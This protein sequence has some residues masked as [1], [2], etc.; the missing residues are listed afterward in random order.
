[1]GT[2][3]ANPLMAEC[4]APVVIALSES[5]SSKSFAARPSERAVYY[6]ILYY[7]ILILYYTILYYTMLY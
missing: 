3:P 4:G 1:M 7:T 2:R 5:L 6:T